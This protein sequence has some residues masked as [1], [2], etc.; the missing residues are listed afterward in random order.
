MVYHCWKAFQIYKIFYTFFK[1]LTTDISTTNNY[2]F[3]I[4]FKMAIS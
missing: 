4:V 1:K 3:I 2:F